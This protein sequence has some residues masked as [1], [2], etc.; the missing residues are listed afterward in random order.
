MAVHDLIL[1]MFT[2]KPV[3]GSPDLCDIMPVEC[4]SIVYFRSQFFHYRQQSVIPFV[5]DNIIKLDLVSVHG[6]LQID[7]HRLCS[8]VIKTEHCLQ[9]SDRSAAVHFFFF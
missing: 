2:E 9:Y 8:A 1:R 7:D 5:I 3:P 6:F 4:R